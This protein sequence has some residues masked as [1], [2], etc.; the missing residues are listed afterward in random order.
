MIPPPLAPPV[1]PMGGRGA[2]GIIT[3]G[4]TR[5][6]FAKFYS[7][8]SRGFAS[9]AA[10]PS[11][12]ERGSPTYIRNGEADLLYGKS[13]LRIVTYYSFPITISNISPPFLVESEMLYDLQSLVY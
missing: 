11:G 13:S 3:L 6:I 7:W 1:L 5:K 2:V 12:G 8:G 9:W 10:S 4:G